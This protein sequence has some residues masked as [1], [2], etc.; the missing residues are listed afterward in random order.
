MVNIVENKN[1]EFA[2]YR[3]DEKTVRS[4]FD[5]FGFY[6]GR[7][8]TKS[9]LVWWALNCESQSLLSLET[10]FE[11]EH[12]FAKSR[13]DKEKTLRNSK[14][15]EALGNKA[16]LEK[17]INIRASDYRFK[18]KVKYYQGY[19][20]RRNQFIKG[21]DVIELIT[22]S[23]TK[24]DFTEQ[25]IEIRNVDLVNSFITFLKETDLLL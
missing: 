4:L 5:T 1:V 25:D 22:L 19:T 8:I 17:R 21:T 12:I 11:I 18:D 6:N 14:N 2:D 7:P 16:L 23:K 24:T 3:F 20:N 10:T 15:L 9:M 13:Q